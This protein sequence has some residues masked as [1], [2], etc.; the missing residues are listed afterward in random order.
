MASHEGHVLAF[1]LVGPGR[2]QRQAVDAVLVRALHLRVEQVAVTAYVLFPRET[3]AS[4]VVIML[5]QVISAGSVMC[6]AGQ[7]AP[8]VQ[9]PLRWARHWNPVRRSASLAL[10]SSL[11]ILRCVHLLIRRA[12]HLPLAVTRAGWLR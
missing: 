7:L 12:L 3:P 8:F 4:S 10:I 11:A 9:R 1:P 6:G 2:S 5:L